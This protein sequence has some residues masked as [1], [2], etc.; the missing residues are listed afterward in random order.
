VAEND[1]PAINI[2]TSTVTPTSNVGA[3]NAGGFTATN[4]TNQLV[5]DIP[6][7]RNVSMNMND[8]TVTSNLVMNQNNISNYTSSNNNMNDENHDST[9]MHVE[10]T[11]PTTATTG[12][13]DTKDTITAATTST[14]T[15]IPLPPPPYHYD[16]TIMNSSATSSSYPTPNPDVLQLWMDVGNHI[17]K[18]QTGKVIF[19]LLLVALRFVCFTS[20]RSETYIFI[21][22]VCL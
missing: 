2:A 21:R 4:T 18:T 11:S 13:T 1:I 12:S 15:A 5:N 14:H 9:M 16:P 22:F 20:H 7:V 6:M 19:K 17:D 8:S 3:L 10:P